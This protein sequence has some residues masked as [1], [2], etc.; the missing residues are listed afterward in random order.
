MR[1]AREV[2]GISHG[3]SL[4]LLTTLYVRDGLALSVDV[5]PHVP[6]LE[7]PL[8]VR[9]PAGVD[10]AAVTAEWPGWW[11]DALDACTRGVE[12]TVPEDAEALLTRPACRAA[13]LALKP[14][15][16]RLHRAQSPAALPIG[17]VLRGVESRIGRW[18]QS[19]EL[20]IAEVPVEGLLWER[21]APAHVLASSRFLGDPAR[22]APALRAVLEDLV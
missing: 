22:T 12:P 9:V 8:P 6:G 21:I 15:I 11:A 13:V 5:E 1:F 7:P 3:V 10:R 16:E 20:H 4:G 2:S 19:V 14:G 17:D 18:A